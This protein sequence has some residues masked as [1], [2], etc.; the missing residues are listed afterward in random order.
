MIIFVQASPL[1][2][3]LSVSLALNPRSQL[4]R[5]PRNLKRQR[6]QTFHEDVPIPIVIDTLPFPALVLESVDAF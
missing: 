5:T 3:S 6:R 1:S 4:F 2:S